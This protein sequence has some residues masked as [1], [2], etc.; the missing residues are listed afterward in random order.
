[1]SSPQYHNHLLEDAKVVWIYAI[2]I[3]YTCTRWV[4]NPRPHPP[5]CYYYLT[6][7]N[8]TARK[9]IS[10]CS[11]KYAWH[12]LTNGKQKCQGTQHKDIQNHV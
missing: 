10:I 6:E 4:L 3:S 7:N 12:S 8:E 1:M 2:F 5:P 11:H 9:K